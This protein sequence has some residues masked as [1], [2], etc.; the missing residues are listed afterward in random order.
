MIGEEDLGGGLGGDGK[1]GVGGRGGARE[2]WGVGAKDGVWNKMVVVI[3]GQG[4]DG[5]ER[6][7][8]C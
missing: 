4:N 8:L 6:W 2:G 7:L 3:Y 1:F 5:S